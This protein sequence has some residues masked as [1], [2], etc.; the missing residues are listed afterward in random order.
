MDDLKIY[1]KNELEVKEL[2]S[3]IELFIP[4]LVMETG[5]KKCRKHVLKRGK[6][7]NSG[8]LELSIG[9]TIKK[10]EQG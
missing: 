6:V 4:D 8:G 3:K 1:G 9:D 10:V 7:V 5:A 2:A